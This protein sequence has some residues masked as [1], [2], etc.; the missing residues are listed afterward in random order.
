MSGMTTTN[1][2]NTSVT[3]DARCKR[4][5]DK[6]RE[7]YLEGR[8]AHEARLKSTDN[9]YQE[10]SKKGRDQRV[11]WFVGYYDRWREQRE[12]YYEQ[13]RKNRTR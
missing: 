8:K 4:S 13:V 7:V 10:K 5:V 11:A 2:V 12:L 9:P 1:D 3:E 6:Y